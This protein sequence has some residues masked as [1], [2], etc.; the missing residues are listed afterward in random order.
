[1]TSTSIAVRSSLFERT[2]PLSSS[3]QWKLTLQEIKLLYIQRQYKRCIARSL[4]ILSTAREPIN[5]VHKT[6]LYFYSGISY[7]AMGRYAHVYSRNKIPMLHSALDCFVTCL[8]VLPDL[9]PVQEDGLSGGLTVG[10]TFG[11]ENED[12]SEDGG[13]GEAF[14]AD[15]EDDDESEF[16]LSRTLSVS[17]S[18]SPSPSPSPSASTPGSGTTS[19]TE[20]IVSSITD[21]IDKTLG[22]S[23]D[24]PFL[25]DD[26]DQLAAQR[27][28]YP[29]LDET[30]TNPRTKEDT[31]IRLMP[32]PL[33]VRKS[34]KPLPLILPS[35]SFSDSTTASS[36]PHARTSSQ[37]KGRITTQPQPQSQ[38]SISIPPRLPL[39][40]MPTVHRR[41][42]SVKPPSSTASSTTKSMKSYNNSI[43]SLQTQLTSTITSLKSHIQEITSLQSARA[44]SKPRNSFQRSVSFWS[45][46]PVKSPSKSSKCRS[47]SRSGYG[48]GRGHGR[49]SFTDWAGS[50]EGENSQ[51][52]SPLSTTSP[53]GY[54]REN[55]QERIVRLRA[56]GWETVGL[57]NVKRGWKGEEYYREFCGGA[58]D[59]LYL[60][61]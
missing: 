37:D 29:G 18:P 47:R 54:K 49:A 58:L 32:S 56:D 5:P 8:A 26:D 1:M 42:P 27:I 53:S 13:F 50:N 15:A 16:W 61:V 12:R 23:E 14:L 10:F 24:D 34:I 55:I 11:L 59:E 57:K 31:E 36:N 21:I 60:D 48:R 35:L 6:Y 52:S 7:E 38:T 44:S 22:C 40:I 20:S 43:T 9:V 39:P 19:P 33:H 46:S 2:S 3:T 28:L 30:E 51:L 4:S 17:L 41:P 45:F 25:S